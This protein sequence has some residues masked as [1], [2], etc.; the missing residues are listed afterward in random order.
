MI[1]IIAGLLLVLGAFLTLTASIGMIRF[2]DLY[3]R[4]H[5]ATKAGTLGITFMLIAASTFFHT[6]TVITESIILIGFIFTAAPIAAHLLARSA[7]KT[8]EHFYNPSNTNELNGHKKPDN[9]S[10]H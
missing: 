7:Y 9:T 10:H 6:L 4:M 5:A 1:K 2:P 3:T 8:N